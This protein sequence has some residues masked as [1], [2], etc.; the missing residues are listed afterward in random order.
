MRHPQLTNVI[1]RVANQFTDGE[2]TQFRMFESKIA[3][4]LISKDPDKNGNFRCNGHTFEL[5]NE[6]GMTVLSGNLANCFIE[7][8]EQYKDTVQLV[9][10][11]CKNVL[12]SA[13]GICNHL[14]DLKLLLPSYLMGIIHTVIESESLDYIPDLSSQEAK[15]WKTR[16]ELHLKLLNTFHLKQSMGISCVEYPE[17]LPKD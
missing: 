13:I 4:L 11:Y 15:A 17:E 2:D 8:H 6:V 3:N 12:A 9:N 14:G 7:Y 16:N 10:E 5:F 1:T